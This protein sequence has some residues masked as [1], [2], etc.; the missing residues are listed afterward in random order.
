MLRGSGFQPP[1]GSEFYIKRDRKNICANKSKINNLCF[2][3]RKSLDTLSRCSVVAVD[4]SVGYTMLR[5]F[6]QSVR[7]RRVI[8]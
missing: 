8:E 3:F 6:V 1:G 5:S 7:R 4:Y 2:P